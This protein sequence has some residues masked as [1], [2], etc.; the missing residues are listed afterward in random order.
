MSLTLLFWP[1]RERL[2][3]KFDPEHGTG[4]FR[5]SLSEPPSSQGWA[6]WHWGTWYAFWTLGETWVFQAGKKQWPVED[7]FLFGN[8][9][10]GRHRE[11][12]IGQNGKIIFRLK[13]R[14][15]DRDWDVTFDQMDLTEVDFFAWLTFVADEPK[16]R[17][18]VAPKH[19]LLSASRSTA[20]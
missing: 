14:A 8:V 1:L 3:V 9:R 16:W 18:E 10:E 13:Y 6:V 17:T 19:A 12:V 20:L 7:D 2:S 4:R 11:F 15:L 5:W